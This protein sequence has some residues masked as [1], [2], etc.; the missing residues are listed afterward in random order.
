LRDLRRKLAG[1]AK[2][3]NKIMS[4]RGLEIGGDFLCRLREIGGDGDLRLASRRGV[5]R[6]A[7]AERGEA[8]HE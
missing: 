3:E 8:K 4:C 5:E 1:R 6:R 2:T 7:S